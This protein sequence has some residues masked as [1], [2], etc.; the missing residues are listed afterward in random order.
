MKKLT[1]PD[2]KK[3]LKG[4]YNLTPDDAMQI[5]LDNL[6]GKDWK[7][8]SGGKLGRMWRD[9]MIVSTFTHVLA[10]EDKIAKTVTRNKVYAELFK[11]KAF[12]AFIRVAGLK[13]YKSHSRC[14]NDYSYWKGLPMFKPSWQRGTITVDKY[15]IKHEKKLKEAAKMLEKTHKIKR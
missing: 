3:L 15:R 14:T 8:G 6:F 4:Q 12:R 10:E 2:L 13:I 7:H 11:S 5:I 1:W 9:P